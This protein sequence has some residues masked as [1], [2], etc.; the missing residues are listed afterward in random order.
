MFSLLLFLLGIRI[1]AP[2]GESANLPYLN[3]KELASELKKN[4]NSIVFFVDQYTDLEFADYAIHEYKEE[5]KFIRADLSDGHQYNC[6]FSPCI[7]PFQKK[8]PSP[9]VPAPLQPAQFLLWVKNSLT[10]GFISVESAGHLHRLLTGH[11]PLVF[12]VDQKGRNKKIPAN[13]TIYSTTA[14]L[15]KT[16]NV[17]IEKGYYL[18][19]PSDHELLPIKDGDFAKILAEPKIF[20]I[21]DLNPKLRPYMA[22]YMIDENDAESCRT[23]I[24]ILKKLAD[25]YSD[26]IQFTTLFGRPSELYKKAS[27]LM[28]LPTP[29]FFVFNT[30][31]IEG[32]RWLIYKKDKVNDFSFVDHFVKGILDDTEFFTVISE[33][34]P[35][36]SP[37][38][39]FRKIVADNFEDLVLNSNDDVLVA[40]T[41]PWCHHCKDLKPVLNETAT[42]L[43]DTHAKI[44]YMDGSLNDI[45]EAVPSVDGY[46]TMYFWPAGKKEEE[47]IKYSGIRRFKDVLNFVVNKSTNSI[48]VPQHNETEISE[49]IRLIQH[50]PTPVP[51]A[52]FG[53]DESEFPSDTEIEN[54]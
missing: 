32:G 7:V 18:F 8:N 54:E 36:Y 21:N 46:P 33:D 27:D 16:F 39:H 42:L 1:K 40:F 49:R 2:V 4:K 31:D 24:E 51:E 13:Y 43:K 14:D 5:V 6:K 28:T 53:E 45:P 44:Y 30:S 17:T 29:Y 23:E 38:E 15:F 11:K 47:P 19:R 48:E 9:V 22:G 41:A 12:S 3:A 34:I 37:D 35:I 10:P 52:E 50:P 25:K 20:D 26:K